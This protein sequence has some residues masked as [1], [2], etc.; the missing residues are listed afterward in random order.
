[1]KCPPNIVCWVLRYVSNASLIVYFSSL[2]IFQRKRCW[3]QIQIENNQK[4]IV[5]HRTLHDQ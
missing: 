4:I 1:M 2:N 3:N 5:K